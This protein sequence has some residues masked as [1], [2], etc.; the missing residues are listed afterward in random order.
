MTHIAKTTTLPVI[1]LR[2]EDRRSWLQKF[3][4][5]GTI[6]WTEAKKEL[7]ALNRLLKE[8][9]YDYLSCVELL[10]TNW[11]L[12]VVAEMPDFPQF[13]LELEETAFSRPEKALEAIAALKRAVQAYRPWEIE[14][15]IHEAHSKEFM[16][17]IEKEAPPGKLVVF[18][19]AYEPYEDNKQRFEASVA[20]HEETAIWV[21]LFTPV[22]AA[23]Y[24]GSNY[25]EGHASFS[26]AD[27]VGYF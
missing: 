25:L 26:R 8:K 2:F 15:C 16:Q 1:E 6:D 13:G 21:M 23:Y 14:S 22:W 11:G 7:D 3:L 18:K 27:F 24:P 4:H 10:K 5:I 17:Q 19:T 12:E 9:H 20:A